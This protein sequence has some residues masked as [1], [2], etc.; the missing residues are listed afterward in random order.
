MIGTF[1]IAWL[2]MKPKMLAM[3]QHWGRRVQMLSPRLARRHNHVMTTC[4]PGP[5]LYA[6]L[7]GELLGGS[8]MK[9]NV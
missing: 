5:G 2:S 3:P 8:A 4:P 7:K 1:D 6:A 9:S